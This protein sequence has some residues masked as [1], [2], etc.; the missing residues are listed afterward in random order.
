ML[1]YFQ[2]QRIFSSMLQMIPGV[3]RVKAERLLEVYPHPQRLIEA[4]SD[5]M[6][7]LEERKL[8][9]ADKLDPQRSQSKLAAV[10][11]KIFTSLDPT[12]PLHL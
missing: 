10:L 12:E 7:P 11:Y 9:L 4:L 1:T 3:S 8:L 2:L 6:R 5:P